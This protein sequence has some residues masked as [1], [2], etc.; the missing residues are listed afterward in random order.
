MDAVIYTS[1]A[2]ALVIISLG[3]HEAAHAVAMM[4]RGIKIEKAGLGIP[5]RYLTL[6]V[7]PNLLGAYVMPE[8]GEDERIAEM[9]PGDQIAIYGAGIVAN[10]LFGMGLVVAE[11]LM[12]LFVTKQ[13]AAQLLY[14]LA[15]TAVAVAVWFGRH[16]FERWIV[17]VLGILQLGLIV[18]LIFSSPISSGNMAGPIGV[19]Q[20]TYS[21]TFSWAVFVAGVISF[22][23][24]IT[25]TLPLIPLDGG[26][27]AGCLL[28]AGAPRKL[29]QNVT[30][31]MMVAL[32]VYVVGG[33]VV[34]LF[35]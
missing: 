23:I 1:L 35:R 32:A 7:R 27:I 30:P 34:R 5:V 13:F 4:K 11:M 19:A 16:F 28:P 25:N 3:V 20:M 21:L 15:V 33:D 22:S 14:I 6:T 24:G 2:A 9:P 26:R 8:S 31:I 18:W 12:H 17:P 29:L 10:I